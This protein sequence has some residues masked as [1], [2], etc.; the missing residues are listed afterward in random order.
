MNRAGIMLTAALCAAAP[1]AAFSPVRVASDEMWMAFSATLHAGGHGENP[2]G[3]LPQ[4]IGSCD[5]A[6]AGNRWSTKNY[7]RTWLPLLR[8]PTE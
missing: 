5:Y 3:A 6:S 2:E 7:Y 1:L 4:A 8:A